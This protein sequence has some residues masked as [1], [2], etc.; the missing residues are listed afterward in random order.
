[1]ESRIGTLDTQQVQRYLTTL[2]EEALK[3]EDIKQ[4]A[5]REL[6]PPPATDA[7]RPAR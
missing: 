1:M 7:P 6:K 3:D 5:A 4:A 2:R